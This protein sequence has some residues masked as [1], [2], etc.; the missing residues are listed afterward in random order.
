MRR[1]PAGCP[2]GHPVRVVVT[3]AMAVVVGGA[4][5]AA[6]AGADAPSGPGARTVPT[7]ALRH[8]P[9]DSSRAAALDSMLAVFRRDYPGY[10]VRVVGREVAYAAL[11]DS[12][13]AVAA[14][15][16]A[17]RDL[18]VCIPALH[19]VTHYFRDAHL[20]VWQG[21]PTP[22]PPVSSTAVAPAAPQRVPI[23]PATP[24]DP[25][26]PTLRRYDARTVV[27]RLPD[28]AWR[29]QR[30]V[31]SLVAARRAD[32]AAAP[33]LVV[34]L[35]GDGGGCTCTYAALLPLIATGAVRGDALDVWA[36]PANAAY[37]RAIAADPGAPDTLRAE[38]RRLLPRLA[39]APDAFVPMSADSAAG[40]YT[41]PA[42]RPR[43]RV[44]AVLVDS[45]CASSCEDFVQAAR[46]SRK[47]TVFSATNT[48]G[49]LDYG[50][51]RPVTLPGWRR[52]RVATAR[53]ARLRAGPAA[54]V[55]FVGLAPDVRLLHDSA[56]GDAAVAFALRHP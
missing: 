20:M 31:D 49:A 17:D 44:V 18:Q 28:L 47:V 9:G 43:P 3:A 26:R 53:S 25:D 41:P 29:Y 27:L 10:Q 19:G 13:R 21:P 38:F 46:Q 39:A 14:T 56:A 16:A 8:A 45:A 22:S 52:L 48:G 36:S 42:V 5:L 11:V 7:H 15:P 34:D 50:N 55:D 12:V 23:A 33:T 37:F 32:L 24:D 35:R 40:V 54:G 6:R 4:L 51:I 2:E 30:V 1:F